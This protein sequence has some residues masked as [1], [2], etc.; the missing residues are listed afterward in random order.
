MLY[1]VAIFFTNL[2]I[3]N[4]S[5][6]LQSYALAHGMAASS[7]TPYLLSIFNASTIPG[8]L[9]MSLAA[10]RFGPLDVFAA[11][12]ASVFYWTSVTNSAGNVA[13]AVLYGV[14]SGSVVSLAQVVIAGITPGFTRLGTRL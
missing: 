12:A 13:F 1:C 10:D 3:F 8:R 7:L 2:V 5:Y 11:T 4:P 9:L 14:F 6:Y